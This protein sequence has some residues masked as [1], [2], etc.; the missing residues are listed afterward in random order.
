MLRKHG[1]RRWNPIVT[2]QTPLGTGLSSASYLENVFISL[3]ICQS[4]LTIRFST[5]PLL[6]SIG[7]VGP[8]CQNPKTRQVLRQLKLKHPI[9]HNFQ[10]FTDLA[11]IDSINESS[12]SSAVGS[13]GLS[14]LHFK[15][16][17]P[18]G[19]RI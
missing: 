6:L 10:P 13:D 3:L 14:S 7:S 17:G 9:D 11:T 16:L 1:R 12:N 5:S 2:S 15:H 19:L 4:L 8:H 18:R